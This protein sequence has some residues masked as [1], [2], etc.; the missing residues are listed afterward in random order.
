MAR[1]LLDTFRNPGTAGGPELADEPVL[2][3]TGPH[4]ISQ[5]VTVG[6]AGATVFAWFAGVAAGIDGWRLAL[7]P[8]IPLMLRLAFD[9]PRYWRFETVVTTRRIVINI[10]TVRDIYHTLRVRDVVGVELRENLLGRLLGFGEVILELEGV[11]A[12]GQVHR[13]VYALD[14]VRRPR[15]LRDAIVE[16]TERV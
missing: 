11:D 7:L 14:Y 16:A 3:R 5:D 8:G 15:E 13:G 6:L 12:E 9:L 2:C 1:A 4:W 10:G